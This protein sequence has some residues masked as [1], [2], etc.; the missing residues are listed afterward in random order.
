V[1]AISQKKSAR[2]IALAWLPAAAYMSLIWFLSSGPVSVSLE[3]V[4]FKDK[5]VHVMEYGTLAVLSAYAILH[6]WPGMGLLRALSW[7]AALTFSWGYLDELHQAFV[8]GR[9]SDVLD[10]LADAIGAFAG[11]TCFGLFERLRRAVS[12]S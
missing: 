10:V 3:G 9:D 4:P 7:A 2:R 1:S 6:S 8:P 12:R 5:G 11:T